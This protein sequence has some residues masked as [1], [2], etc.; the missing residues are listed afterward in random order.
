MSSLFSPQK[1][2]Q[3]VVHSC[4]TESPVSEP[5]ELFLKIQYHS[6]FS[7]PRNRPFNPFNAF[8][9]KIS[10]LIFKE[11]DINS[12]TSFLLSKKVTFKLFHDFVNFPPPLHHAALSN[13]TTA[14]IKQDDR[15]G[16]ITKRRAG[17]DEIIQVILYNS[18]LKNSICD[19][20]IDKYLLEFIPSGCGFA[21]MSSLERLEY[22]RSLRE[23]ELNLQ[24]TQ[25]IPSYLNEQKMRGERT[26]RGERRGMFYLS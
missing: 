18:I 11:L 1:G 16:N 20:M 25:E 8:T 3:P 26:Q 2:I 21:K 4:S 24:E 5:D 12:L 19:V 23:H 15:S 22:K 9:P 7:K 13:I 10:L 14:V 17:R 6:Q